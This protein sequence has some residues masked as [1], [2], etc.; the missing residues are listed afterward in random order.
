MRRCGW[1][2]N[3]SGNYIFCSDYCYLQW[4]K[5][6]EKRGLPSMPAEYDGCAY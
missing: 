4:E 3:P 6:Q 2:A 5:N 1:C